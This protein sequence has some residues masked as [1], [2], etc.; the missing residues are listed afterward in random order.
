MLDSAGA[1]RMTTVKYY[2]GLG[3]LEQTVA[4]GASPSGADLVMHSSRDRAG[5]IVQQFCATPSA[6]GGAY[7]DGARF[8]P[9]Q[10]RR[11]A[12][13]TPTHLLNT[14]SHRLAGKWL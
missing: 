13:P 1:S 12:T 11:M 6:G 7:V 2:D 14:S 10:R 3:R 9:S 8:T 4:V 5:R